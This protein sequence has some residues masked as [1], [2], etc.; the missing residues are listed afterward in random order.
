MAFDLFDFD[1]VDNDTDGVAWLSTN[2]PNSLGFVVLGNASEQIDSSYIVNGSDA[3]VGQFR[4]YFALGTTGRIRFRLGSTGTDTGAAAGPQ[5][6]DDA[7][8]N[9]GLAI[10]LD[11]VTTYKWRLSILVNDDTLEPYQWDNTDDAGDEVTQAVATAIAGA[12]SIKSILVDIS[13][14]FIDWDTLQTVDPGPSLEDVD[15]QKAVYQLAYELVLPE[16]TGGD[17]TITH[18]VSGLPSGL[19]FTASTRTISGTP[20]ATGT[21]TVTYTATD[22]NSNT[23]SVTFD[24]EVVSEISLFDVFVTEDTAGVAA[25][26][27][28]NPTYVVG[29]GLATLVNGSNSGTQLDSQIDSTWIANGSTAY[30]TGFSFDGTNGSM[31]VGNTPGGHPTQIVDDGFTS[32]ARSRLGIAVRNEDGDT[33][34]WTLA[35]LLASDLTDPYTF[36]SLQMSQAGS[37]SS[38][39]LRQNV[40]QADELTIIIVDRNHK[41]IDWDNLRFNPTPSVSSISDVEL[42]H[43]DSLSETLPAGS[44][45]Q[46][47]LTY[48]V[49]G[50]TSWMS[51]DTSTRELTGTAPNEQSTT[52][53]SYTVTDNDGDTATTTFDV[54]VRLGLADYDTPTG[55]TLLSRALIDADDSSSSW[56]WEAQSDGELLDGS[57]QPR[58]FDFVRIRFR[59]NVDQLQLN[60]DSAV[61]IEDY[62]SSGGDGYDLSIHIQDKDGVAS[63]AVAEEAIL[64]VSN[65]NT[66]RWEAPT[67]FLAILDRIQSDR[68]RFILAF[69][70]PGSTELLASHTLAN[71]TTAATVEQDEPEASEIS[72]SHTLQNVT[73]SVSVEVILP[74]LLSD[75]VVPAGHVE[76][77]VA[78]ITSGRDSLN[79]FYRSD[80]GVGTL[81]AGTIEPEPGTVITRIRDRN[82]NVFLLNDSPD[83]DDITAFFD[84]GGNGNDLT[85]H[86][87]DDTGV[88]SIVVADT[89]NVGISSAN[90]AQFNTSSEFDTIVNRIANG[91]R[92][93]LAFTRATTEVSVVSHTLANVTASA[94]ATKSDPSNTEVTA[95]HTL[96]SVTAE[97][98]LHRLDPGQIAAEHTLQNI[99]AAGAVTTSGAPAGTDVTTAA[100]TL[101]NVAAG[102]TGEQTLPIA[103]EVVAEPS[104]DGTLLVH[105]LLEQVTP[106]PQNVTA[107]P[108][109]TGSLTVRSEIEIVEDVV[110]AA[111]MISG[112]L[113]VDADITQEDPVAPGQPNAPIVVTSSRGVLR[114]SWDP[115]SNVGSGIDEYDLRYRRSGSSTWV[116]IQGVTSPHVIIGLIDSSTYQVQIRGV[117]VAGN[118]SWS[119]SG[120]GT[121]RAAP[122][123]KLGN[124]IVQADWDRNGQFNHPLSNLHNFLLKVN[125]HTYRGRDYGSHFFGKSVAGKVT[126]RLRNENS[127]F[128]RF[129]P[130]SSLHAYSIT[131]TPIRLLVE[132]DNSPNV[133]RT[134]WTGKIDKVN[135]KQRT[136]GQDEVTFTCKD[137]ITEISQ[138]ELSAPYR[139]DITTADAMTALLDAADIPEESI[140]NIDG[141]FLMN[142][143]WV[144][145]Q[146]LLKSIRELEETEGGF[147]YIDEFNRIN[148]E[149]STS[150]SELGALESQLTLNDTTSEITYIKPED[151]L[152]DVTNVV[153]VP[154][155]Q[156]ASTQPIELWRLGSSLLEFVVTGLPE[157]LRFDRETRSVVG[158]PTNSAV[159]LHPIMFTVTDDEGNTETQTFNITIIDS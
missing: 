2:T 110:E 21:S 73:A 106:D 66:A 152:R 158:I 8:S 125:I 17:G 129:N 151:P 27:T 159:G 107:S 138:I 10:R 94:S 28:T 120:S 105:A 58:T 44:G 13:D 74:L 101:Q 155:R 12:S 68:G 136:S 80:T 1:N 122:T 47:P 38:L 79:F 70:E 14:D 104:I 53:I 115:P 97:A 71:V 18:S 59:A 96:Q 95:S 135:F 100:H 40:G 111:P 11:D 23:D 29:T 133:F 98:T 51:F 124:Y 75:F 9:L 157:G 32:N 154:I 142:K 143:W 36:T 5:L 82:P 64:S 109:I 83:V 113:S 3:Y 123:F 7:E 112:T 81:E 50:L 134:L 63:F 57:L 99:T 117:N 25:K 62:F 61:N 35:G 65:D 150:R 146:S 26:G 72:I 87:Q 69:T 4:I 49:S 76:V 137:I 46:T 78:L 130:D 118:G 153:K 55:H 119:A 34:K 30:L 24:I 147:F 20:T 85:I 22:G 86:I 37:G 88:A 148:F 91:D 93:I 89:L 132:D 77:D 54:I 52:E 156:F 141:N 140:G 56:Y 43:G 60:D 108:T 126:F 128:D 39:A 84:A 139:E 145:N 131:G 144:P 16:G 92:F 102:A 19:S 41:D 31:G 15:D 114:V 116:T 149:N 90:A 127:E 121:T 67:D 6:T 48:S 45:D 103:Q 33:Y 42:D